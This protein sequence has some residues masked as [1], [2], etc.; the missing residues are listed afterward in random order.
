MMGRQGHVGVGAGGTGGRSISPYMYC[1]C[2]EYDSYRDQWRKILVS[3]QRKFS[4]APIKFDRCR[5]F[6]F[7]FLVFCFS[8]LRAVLEKVSQQPFRANL[9]T[10]SSDWSM[11]EFQPQ[12]VYLVI[13]LVTEQ[14]DSVLNINTDNSVLD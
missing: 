9:G 10:S 6:C 11:T 14:R 4:H 7:L 3:T 12:R 1:T 5:I 8:L 13:Y 2:T